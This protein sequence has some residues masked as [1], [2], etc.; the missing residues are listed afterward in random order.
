MATEQRWKLD[1][2]LFTADAN[3]AAREGRS[4]SPDHGARLGPLAQQFATLTYSLLDADTVGEVLRQVIEATTGLVAGADVVSVTLREPDGTFH[5]PLETDAVAAKLDQ[6]QYELDEGPCLDAARKSG[7]A[8]AIS[9]VLASEP[10]WPR[11]GPAA[12]AHGMGAVIATALRPSAQPPQLSGALNIYSSRPHGLTELDQHIALLLATHASLALAHTRAVELGELQATH[13]RKAIDSRDVIGQAKG[14]LMARRGI[15]ADQAFDILRRISQDINI[16]L[17][18][19]A[20]T[21]ATRHT[22]LDLP[23]DAPERRRLGSPRRSRRW[24]D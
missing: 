23:Q 2:D 21:L 12:A 19:L 1:K 17:A 15:A 4:P 13:L 9:P 11:F 16:K 5:T 8:V 22:E 6:I 24:P 18:D 14:I 3:Q 7:P 20:E 10:R